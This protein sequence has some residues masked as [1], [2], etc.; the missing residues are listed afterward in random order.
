MAASSSSS[1]AS[2]QPRM[3]EQ[4]LFYT[5]PPARAV[6]TRKVTAV[7]LHREM[8]LIRSLMPTF[9]FVAVDTQF[10]GV[11]H[12]HPRGAGVTADDRYAAV[13]ANAD[14]LCLLQLG[15][16]LSAAD[17]RLPVDGALV[18]F[19]WEFDFAGFDARYHR[20]APE[21][22]QFLRAQGFDF[23]AARLAGVP[24][25]AFAAELAAS[26]I[27]G[28]RGV[29]WVAFGGMYGVAF[30]LR[31]ATG[32]APLPAT[33]LGFLAQVGAV[34]GTQVFDAKHMASLLHMHGGLAAVGGMLRLPPQLPRR[35]MAGQNSVMAIQLFMELRRRFNDL[36]GSLHSCSL[37]I[38]GLT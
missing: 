19:M 15:I 33:R 12:P 22:V 29:T 8:S 14:E 26:G 30:L 17:G 38:E 24:A 7:N 37:K 4:S 1:M 32:G 25:L 34:F 27:L 18:E 5:Q 11:V 2:S 13:R 3:M 20:H 36:G 23:E 35:H 16:T 21:S 31:L 9:P 10:P 28:L 6:H